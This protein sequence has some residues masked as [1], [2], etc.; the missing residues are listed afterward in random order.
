[1]EQSFTAWMAL[2]MATSTLGLR[3]RCQI[4]LQWCY[5]H[6]LCTIHTPTAYSLQKC[7]LKD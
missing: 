3:R 4:Y 2:L 5:V 1:M 7:S 6:R